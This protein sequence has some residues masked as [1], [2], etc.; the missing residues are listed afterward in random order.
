ML[1]AGTDKVTPLPCEALHHS[2][3]FVVLS[4]SMLAAWAAQPDLFLASVREVSWLT[5]KIE[6]RV[7]HALDQCIVWVRQRLTPSDVFPCIE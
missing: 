1:T 4:A 6:G 5:A 7:P 2:F 3:P